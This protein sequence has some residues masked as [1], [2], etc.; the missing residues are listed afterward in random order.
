[1]KPKAILFDLDGTLLNSA[2]DFVWVINLMLKQ[3]TLPPITFE[4]IKQQVSDGASAMIEAAFDSPLD[5]LEHEDLKREFLQGYAKALNAESHLYDGINELLRLLDENSI[6]WGIVTNKPSIYA[7]AI[8]Q[9]FN[10]YQRCAIL[11]CPEHV[12]K[13]KPDPQ[14][15]IICTNKLSIAPQNCWYIGDHERDVKAGNAADMTTVACTYGYLK[16]T[17]NAQLWEANH[18]VDTPT[19]LLTLIKTQL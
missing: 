2:P 6:P 15:L 14:G 18:V 11:V 16:Q 10:L 1:M 17:D 13:P 9:H 12:E 19:A 5:G 8:L 3:R 4:H 7:Q